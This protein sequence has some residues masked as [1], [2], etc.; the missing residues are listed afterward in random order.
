[1]KPPKKENRMSRKEDCELLLTAAAVALEYL[2]SP[3]FPH[4]SPLGHDRK[5]AVAALREALKA[6]EV[7]EEG[8]G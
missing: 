1:M 6:F 2:A 5:P 7:R 3:N 4:K 8:A